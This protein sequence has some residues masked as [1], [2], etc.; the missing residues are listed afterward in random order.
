M[1][2]V[3]ETFAGNGRDKKTCVLNFNE[4]DDAGK[5]RLMKCIT[6]FANRMRTLTIYDS[7]QLMG[8]ILYFIVPVSKN[9]SHLPFIVTISKLKLFPPSFPFV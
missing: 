8:W 7:T 4:F 2:D 1:R 9:Y 5:K 6:K 3:C